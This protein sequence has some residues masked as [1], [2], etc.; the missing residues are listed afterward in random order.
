[1]EDTFLDEERENNCRRVVDDSNDA[2][3]GGNEYLLHNKSWDVYMREKKSLVKFYIMW[4][5]QV[6]M[7]RRLFGS[8]YRIMLSRCQMGMVIL[9]Y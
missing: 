7:E 6:L 2:G 5:C 4:K 3:R 1:M 8:L 9:Y